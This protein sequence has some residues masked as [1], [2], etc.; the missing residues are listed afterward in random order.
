MKTVPSVYDVKS[1]M[2]AKEGMSENKK[3]SDKDFTSLMDALKES[4]I[5][6]HVKANTG[7]EK[8]MS[9]KGMQIHQVML[10]FEKAETSM[11]LAIGLRNRILDAYREIMQMGA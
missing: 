4:V 8:F 2:Q 7:S 10:A 3:V 5:E 11:K 9:D 1:L 6:P